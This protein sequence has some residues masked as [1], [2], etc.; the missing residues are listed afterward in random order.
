[1]KVL[2]C[3]PEYYGIEYEIN[4]WM[5]IK[6][7]PDRKSALKQWGSLYNKLVSFGAG[8]ELI[9]PVKHMPDMVFTANA[10]FVVDNKVILS[11][12]RYPERRGEEFYFKKWFEENG[13]EV[14]RLDNRFY[15]EG[16]G[17]LLSA[18][19]TLYA[20]YHFRSDIFSH[21]EIAKIVD[22]EVISLELVDRRFYHLDTAFAPL[23]QD[24]VMYVPDAFDE[25]ASIVIKERF[26]NVIEIGME[27]ALNFAANAVVFKDKIITSGINGHL[28]NDLK[29]IGFDVFSL[30]LSEF[31]KAGGAAKCLVLYLKR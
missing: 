3:S 21:Q 5:D 12:F 1:M 10:G 27:S 7:Q 14:I 25:Y 11:N 31:I 30:D 15:F 9:M 17:D 24:S 26:N 28:L 29:K 23:S 4:P 6:N 22:R 18:G 13:Y 19:D 16:E 2:M 8:V 20:G